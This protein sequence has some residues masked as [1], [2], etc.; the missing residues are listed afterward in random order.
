MAGRIRIVADPIGSVEVELI[1]KN[2]RTL[3]AI[4]KALPIE[5][6]AMRW[7]DEV[8][9]K[10]P[11]DVGLENPQEVVEVGDVAYWPP[12]R[13]IC[14]FFGPTPASRSPTEIRPASPVNV[15]GKVVGNP[16]VFSRI[17]DGDRIRV[18]KI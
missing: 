6:R 10:T 1:D 17:K 7:G 12:G 16:K 2:P 8:Y 4:L 5:S 14:I 9:F 15:F 13:S 11:V 3:E 18:E